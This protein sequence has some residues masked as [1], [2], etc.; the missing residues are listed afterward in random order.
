MKVMQKVH[1]VSMAEHNG[2]KMTRELV[3][4][5]DFLLA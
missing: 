2:E 5:E 1:N 4:G 3:I